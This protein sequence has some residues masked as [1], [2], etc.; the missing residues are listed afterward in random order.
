M[1]V[2]EEATDVIGRKV[3]NMVKGRVGEPRRLS[4]LFKTFLFSGSKKD[5]KILKQ[6]VHPHEFEGFRHIQEDR[7]LASSRQS[8][9]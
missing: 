3:A 7:R 8:F 4:F 1:S 5:S 9:C 6:T 2:N